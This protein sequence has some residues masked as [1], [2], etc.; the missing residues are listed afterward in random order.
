MSLTTTPFSVACDCSANAPDAFKKSLRLS[1]MYSSC[2]SK[3]RATFIKEPHATHLHDVHQI[4]VIEMLMKPKAALLHCRGGDRHQ[5]ARRDIRAVPT[6]A[7]RFPCSDEQQ[8]DDERRAVV[9]NHEAE[10]VV[11]Q[12]PHHVDDE[13]DR[14]SVV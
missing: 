14:K 8:Q 7:V 2:I 6:H 13:L 11:L 3:A 5:D 9:V 1:A 10:L 12:H 4:V